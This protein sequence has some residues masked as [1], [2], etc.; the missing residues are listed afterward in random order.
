MKL[1]YVGYEEDSKDFWMHICDPNL[2]GMGWASNNGAILVPPNEVIEKYDKFDLIDFLHKSLIGDKTLPKNFQK[3][4]EES[5]ET[6]F[7]KGM[8]LELIDKK[9]LSSMTTARV[10]NNIGGRLEMRYDND[11]TN[12]YFWC[13]EKSD[14]IHPIGWSSHVGHR[15][16]ATE[17][18][19]RKSCIKYE[20]TMNNNSKNVYEAD[21]CSPNMFKNSNFKS[22]TDVIR[23]LKPFK[24]GMKLEAIDPYYPSS[25][26][27]A[28]VQNILKDDY[29]M[30]RIDGYNE[31][32][33]DI[34]YHRTSSSIFPAGFCQKNSLRLRKPIDYKKAFNWKKYLSETNSEFAPNELFFQHDT[35]NPF[36]VGMKLE[37]VD[38]PNPNLICVATVVA[39]VDRL[40]RIHFDGWEKQYDQWVDFES[41]DIYPIGWC[42][43][44]KYELQPPP[45]SQKKRRSTR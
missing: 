4:V 38:L 11:E 39:I 32:E 30:I 42:E 44:V 27:V 8:L 24:V 15:I 9:E 22:E 21:E 2:H 10:T 33:G 34:C 7:S 26:C 12:S 43:L 19:K 40:L 28:T 37:S 17:D 3:K 35:E 14:L 16:Q 18:Y 5:L 1:R 29:L 6:K 36:K 45:A 23:N 25:L 20:H 31:N 41:S 13:H